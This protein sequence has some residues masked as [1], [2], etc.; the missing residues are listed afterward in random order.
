M[1]NGHK[2]TL[3]SGILVKMCMCVYAREKKNANKIN[4]PKKK[5]QVKTRANECKRNKQN[6]EKGTKLKHR[7][8]L[9]L[10][11]RMLTDPFNLNL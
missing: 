2:N 10:H 7:N 8:D 9:R 5:N 4:S 6:K 1:S 3:N 11:C